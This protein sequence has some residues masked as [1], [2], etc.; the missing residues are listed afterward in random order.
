[1]DNGRVLR[2]AIEHWGIP[3]Q[4]M[5]LF[6]EMGELQTALTHY[7]RDRIE[8]PS[9]EDEIADVQVMLNQMKIIFDEE[10]IDLI[11]EEKLKRLH[12]MIEH[13]KQKS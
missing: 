6:E 13:E 12:N 1:M 8:A 7:L 11:Y 3:S 9:V 10:N 2:E 5:M 4:I